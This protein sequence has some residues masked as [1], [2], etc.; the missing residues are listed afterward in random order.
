[1]P[2]VSSL[3][4][5]AV[6]IRVVWKS[7]TACKKLVCASLLTYSRCACVASLSPTGFRGERRLP[8]FHDTK[9]Q[10]ADGAWFQ[11]QIRRCSVFAFMQ[12]CCRR[13]ETL[14]QECLVSVRACFSSPECP[15]LPPICSAA[16]LLRIFGIVALTE[17][18][19]SNSTVFVRRRLKPLAPLRSRS[20]SSILFVK[21]EAVFVRACGCCVNI[22]RSACR[23]TARA[24]L[25]VLAE[26]APSLAPTGLSGGGCLQH[27]RHT[28]YREN[29]SVVTNLISSM[30][31]LF[32]MLLCCRQG[33]TRCQE[34]LF[35]VRAFFCSRVSDDDTDQAPASE[36][37]FG[38]LWIPCQSALLPSC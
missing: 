19:I 22:V 9:Y 17:D 26:C 36:Q 3:L 8:H 32:F 37:T 23:N 11:I 13:A 18:S 33:R 27:L 15:M 12:T 10:R 24:S 34:C 6:L 25:D 7:C 16:F 35:C 21:T 31:F 28:T 29:S 14:R 30:R 5:E 4:A 38:V 20:A 2:R 1:M